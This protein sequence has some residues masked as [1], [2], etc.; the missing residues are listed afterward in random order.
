MNSLQK[1]IEAYY[2]SIIRE[3]LETLIINNVERVAS[4]KKDVEYL[5]VFEVKNLHWIIYNKD[6]GNTTYVWGDP[7]TGTLYKGAH[8]LSKYKSS[9]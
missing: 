5:T 4:Q 6:N 8:S 2:S 1:E 3:K 9:A 7:E